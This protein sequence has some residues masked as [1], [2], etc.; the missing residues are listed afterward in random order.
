[1]ARALWYRI[2]IDRDRWSRARRLPSAATER[3]LVV[4]EGVAEVGNAAPGRSVA[5]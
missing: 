5:I 3:T 2:W 1:M 4:G